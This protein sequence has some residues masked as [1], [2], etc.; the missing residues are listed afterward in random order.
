[1]RRL[2]LKEVMEQ[3]GG[4]IPPDAVLR[5]DDDEHAATA[6]AHC[7]VQRPVAKPKPTSAPKPKSSR[8]R[9]KS[10]LLHKV[11]GWNRFLD[12]LKTQKP[13]LHP[14]SVAVWCWLWRG[15]RRG[16][17][18]SSERRL[19]ERFGVSRNSIRA[20]IQDLVAA[21]FLTVVRRGSHNRTSTIYRIHPKPK[22]SSLN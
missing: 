12:N 17:V 18:R 14:L 3:Y 2:T 5:P 4:I 11:T 6:A 15:E 8:N 16:F 21:G 9:Q 13:R 20:R 22:K 19:A 10:P 1:M 7:P